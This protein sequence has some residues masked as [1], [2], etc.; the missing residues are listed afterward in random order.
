MTVP[1][2]TREL[3]EERRAR[4]L[5]RREA[6]IASRRRLCLR[7][8]RSEKVCLCDA[9]RPF[10]PGVEFVILQHPWEAKRQNTGTGRL[11]HLALEGSRIMVGTGFDDD[12]EVDRLI[13]DSHFVAV[14]LYPGRDSVNIGDGA[15]LRQTLAGGMLRVF[16][17]DGT[18]A[19]ARTMLRRSANLQSLPRICFS[20]NEPSRF[21]MKRQPRDF[22]LATIEAVYALLSDLDRAGITDCGSKKEALPAA[23]DAMVSIHRHFL[24]QGPKPRHRNGLRRSIRRRWREA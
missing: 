6:E 11:T 13:A 18:W 2:L 19:H 14:L 17:L 7:C 15:L 22:C 10:D 24:S 16:V 3:Y 5:L 20:W 1:R 8:R 9:I 4:F 23:L 21:E 12:D